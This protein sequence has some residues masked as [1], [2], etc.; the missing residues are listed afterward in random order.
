MKVL[1]REISRPAEGI[2]SL[3]LVSITGEGLEPFTAGAHIDL[4]L[5]NGITRQYSL[6]NDVCDG[7]YRVCVNLDANSRGGSTWLH[8]VLAEGDTLTI[9]APRNNFPLVEDAA[10]SILIAGGIG[11]TP[12]FAMVRRLA[13]LRRPWRLYHCTRTIARTPFAEEIRALAAQSD[14]EIVHIHDGIPGIRPLDIGAVVAN[15]PEATHFYCCGPAPLMDS[16]AAATTDVPKGNV[17]VEHFSNA[18]AA[19]RADD[20]AFDVVCARS[21]KRIAVPSGISILGAL[22]AAGLAPLCSC[23]EGICGTCET[24]VLKGNPDHRDMVLTPEERESNQTIIICV[25]RARDAEIILD[26]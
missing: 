6:V 20:R 9:S 2:R 4:S 14:G 19:A 1:V 24:V 18:N 11:I 13:T 7:T 8:E 21:G 23:R 22:E 15:A 3:T 26:I 5:P 17:H 10:M 25:S 12:I 16:F